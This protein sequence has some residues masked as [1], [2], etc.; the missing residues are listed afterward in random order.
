MQKLFGGVATALITPF[1]DEKI[2]F[3]AL[4][5]LVDRQLKSGVDGLV[6]LGSTGEPFSLSQQEKESVFRFVVR[7]AKE[8]TKLIFGCGNPSLPI[9]VEEAK[10]SQDLGADGLLVA[11]P[12]YVKCS[13][14]GLVDY[15]KKICRAVSIPLI[16]YNV[17]SRTGVNLQSDTARKIAEFP[18]LVG[19]KE[20][21]GDMLQTLE[22]L[23]SVRDKLA[24]YSGDDALNFPVLASGGQGVVS[25]LSNLF[26]K[27]LKRLFRFVKAGNLPEARKLSER[28]TPLVFALRSDVNPVPVKCA[29]ALCGYAENELRPPLTKLDK[30]RENALTAALRAFYSEE[31]A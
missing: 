20:A 16:A 31:N 26:P 1:R 15:Y 27:E 2:D 3:N 23:R 8:K 4:E 24:V 17:P 19:I 6:V 14:A 25:V 22:T 13:Q 5:R 30:K 28:L 21:S 12:Y 29:L 11:T 10:K 9:A 7:L 18:N